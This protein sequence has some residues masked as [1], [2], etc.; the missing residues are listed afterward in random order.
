[1]GVPS[2]DGDESMFAAN[3]SSPSE[4]ASR[5]RSRSRCKSSP[6]APC[7]SSSIGVR[8]EIWIYLLVAVLAITAIEWLTYHRRV[9]V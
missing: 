1:M 3:L 7:R 4:S 2:G 8:R 6:P 5:P 9:T